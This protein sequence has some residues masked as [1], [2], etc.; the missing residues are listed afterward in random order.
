MA[1]KQYYHDVDLQLVSQLVGARLQNL[2][3]AAMT[4]M[5]ATLG[6]TNTGLVVYNTEDSRIYTWSGSKFD[7]FQIDVVGDIK[8]AGTINPANAASVVKTPGFQYVVDVAGTLSAVGVTF[9]PFA[10]VEVG[11][12]VLFTSATTAFVIERN[13]IIATTTTAG[14]VRLASQVEANTGTVTD[15]AITA[16]TL[17]G[18]LDTQRY[19]RQYTASVNLVANVP[20][21]VTH[22]LSLL[23]QNAFTFNL[24]MSNHSV[25]VDVV[26]VDVNSISMTSTSDLTGAVV[27]V[28]GASG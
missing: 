12:Q 16:S 9:T 13:D 7:P 10:N 15:G 14:N 3:S 20:L 5:A 21:T 2:T 18:K 22:G 8:F 27:T 24:M 26:S 4:T 6:V 23:N 1:T 17:Q 19:A 25:S 11:D 28:V